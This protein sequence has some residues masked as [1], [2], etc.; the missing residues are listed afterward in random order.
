MAKLADELRTEYGIEECACVRPEDALAL[1]VGEGFRAQHGD[2][3]VEVVLGDRVV[4]AEEDAL[5][6]ER[7]DRAAAFGARPARRRGVEPELAQ[8][9]LEALAHAEVVVAA[10]D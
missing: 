3:A 5:G 9:P 10:E 6:A 1:A 2:G 4:A 8:A 7:L